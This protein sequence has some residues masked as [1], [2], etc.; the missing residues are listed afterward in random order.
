VPRLSLVSLAALLLALPAS[1]Q[2]RS[3]QIGR[4][5]QGRAV[6][7]VRVGSPAAPRKILVVG[8]IHGNERAGVAVSRRLRRARPPRGTELWLVDTV[9][10]DGVE[11]GRR[12]NARGVDLNR[13]F[14]VGWR[15][16]GR[17]F[18]PFY[19]GPEPFSEPESRLVRDLTLRIK[20][21][22]T[23]WYHQMK[24]LVTKHTGGD[25]RL[26]AL[27]ARAARMRHRRLAPLPGLATTWQNRTVRGSTSFVVELPGG[28]LSSRSTRRHAG[29]LLSVAKAVAPPRTVRKRIPFG[30]DR[31]RQMRAYARRH[32]GIDSFLLERPRVIVEHYTASNSFSSAYQTFARNRPDA[33]LGELPGVCAHFVIDRRGRIYDL[34]PLTIMCRH[35]VGLNY[36]AIGIEHVGTSDG[37]VLR[38]RRQ[39]AASLRLTRHLQGRFGIRTG[40]VIG[41]AESLRSRFHRE[42]VARLRRQTHGDFRRASM[43]RFRRALMRLPAP[44]SV[45]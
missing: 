37:G 38:N 20:P 43:R 9:N 11:A 44:A 7:A 14:P 13:N 2:A 35:T 18:D 10:P 17:P 39:I 25:V 4:S 19:P 31:K 40:D 22:V 15:A 36:T 32:Y 42:R 28:R 45:R 1:A 5:A 23:V 26:E 33:E 41:H 6:T 24:N 8:A 34:V 29:A 30:D 3:E 27:Y 16:G 12:Q 21:R